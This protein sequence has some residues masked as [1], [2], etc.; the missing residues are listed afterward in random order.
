MIKLIKVCYNFWDDSDIGD[1]KLSTP[2]STPMLR[3]IHLERIC[4][5][6]TEIEITVNAKMQ[7]SLKIFISQKIKFPL[8]YNGYCGAKL[9]QPD[10]PRPTDP[11]SDSLI[12]P[13]RQKTYET[14][15]DD[16]LQVY[17]INFLSY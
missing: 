8:K 4:I 9:G 14:D 15:Q 7:S 3:N 17:I 11:N 1:V 16:D 10:F 13:F 12:P 2:M 6:L 5:L